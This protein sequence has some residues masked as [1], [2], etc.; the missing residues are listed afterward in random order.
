M[1]P[2]L[3]PVSFS[4]RAAM[5]GSAPWRSEAAA[6]ASDWPAALAA[7]GATNMIASA[8][9]RIVDTNLDQSVQ[10]NT[11]QVDYSRFESCLHS[12]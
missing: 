7:T 10:S 9:L 6:T 11:D 1:R 2:T 12:R 8:T 3:T 4:K 5:E